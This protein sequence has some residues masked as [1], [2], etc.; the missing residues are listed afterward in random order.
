M[1]DVHLPD[2]TFPDMVYGK[3]ETPWDLR[4]WLYKGG[5]GTHVTLVASMID[6][7]KLGRPLVERIELVRQIHEVLSNHVG[8]GGSRATTVGCFEILSRFFIWA[9]DC[10]IEL[11]LDSVDQSYRYWTDA[12]L[13]RVRVGEGLSEGTAYRYG[14]RVG[15]VLDRVLGRSSPILR[16][17][18]LRK[19]KSAQ[20]AVSPKADKQNLEQTFD[21]GHFLIDLADGLGVNAIWGSLPLRLPLRN[22]QVLELTSGLKREENAKPPNPKY[23]AQ[24]KQAAK[25]VKELRAKWVA[26]TSMR[27]RSP[28]IN[29]RIQAEMFMFM[30]QPAVNLAQAH[31]LR[32][33]QWSYRASTN[34]YEVRTFKHRRGGPVEFEIY[35]NYRQV[36]E[37]YLKW[38]AAIFPND[39]DGLLFPLL[40]RGGIPSGRHPERAPSFRALQDAC[41]RTGVKY[42]P[43]S[44]L[45]NTNVNWSLR[46]SQ[47]PDLTAAEKQH[48]TKT[49]LGV[50]EKPSQQR[51]MVQIKGFWAKHDPAQA[52]VGPG[53][54]KH[55]VPEPIADIPAK[56]TQ[57]DCTT[58]AGC[59]FCVNQRDIDSLDHV[60]SLASYRYLKSFELSTQGIGESQKEMPLHPA[61]LV[62]ERVTS[63]LNYI[64]SSSQRRGA[65]VKEALLRIEEGRYHS[66]WAS[67]IERL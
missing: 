14:G 63:K 59:L 52:S 42:L 27:T 26:D 64:E 7:G 8:R 51:A 17:T 32:M 53:S 37:R 40:G 35:S 2:L 45:R 54:C 22:G 11:S 62:I 34:G 4:R 60:W 15:W 67:M 1:L 13:L 48:S 55:K 61:E 38:R 10:E 57:P 5:S 3:W 66:D 28:M 43:P 36:F 47:D 18:R 65:W 46:H 20:R 19:P 29:L 23:P 58:P 56:A 12:L 31:K 44:S 25:R 30:G 49:L 50:Y 16:T 21:L 9:D 39:S 41:M 24:S 6:A 33:D